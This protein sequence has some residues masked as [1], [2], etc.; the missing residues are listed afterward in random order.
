MSVAG[1]ECV[2]VLVFESLYSSPSSYTQKHEQNIEH[3][4]QPAS[5]A[6]GGI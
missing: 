1:A 3:L 4:L 5:G 6:S 2:Y